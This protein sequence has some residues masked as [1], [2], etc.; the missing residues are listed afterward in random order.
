MRL[1]Y[2]IIILLIACSSSAQNDLSPKL[3]SFEN[4]F[5]YELSKKDN[6]KLLI[7]LHGGVSNPYFDQAVEKIEFNYLIEKNNSFIEKALENGYDLILPIKNDSINWLKKPQKSYEILKKLLNSKNKKYTSIVL[8]GH[9]DGGT[10][11]FKIFYKNSALFSGLV[12][13]NGYPQHGNFHKKVDYKS[14]SN[15]LIVFYGTRN[16]K[17]IPY[18][19]MLTEYCNQKKNNRNTFFYVINGNHSFSNYTDSD[20]IQLF[21][22]FNGE[23]KNTN[24]E[25]SPIHGFVKNDSLIEFYPFRKKI[26]QKFGYGKEFY[27]ENKKQSKNYK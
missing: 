2:S 27:N 8:S 1:F 18:E 10:G 16:D 12:V 6:S 19:F 4:N 9:S 17:T 15:K 11:S 23:V 26:L 14:I 7:F 20:F 3:K 21:S 24:V 25:S 22:I 5:Y 13:F